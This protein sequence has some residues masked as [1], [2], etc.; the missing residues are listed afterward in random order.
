MIFDPEN[1]QTL[2]LPGSRLAES[3]RVCARSRQ[4]FLGLKLLLD[5]ADRAL[6]ESEDAK[7]LPLY[8]RRRGHAEKVGNEGRSELTRLHAMVAGV[9][10]GLKGYGAP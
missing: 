10:R 2:F 9:R 5:F 7:A 1:N 3:S 4:S 6:D 8:S